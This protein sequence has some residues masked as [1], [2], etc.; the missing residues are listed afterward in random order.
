MLAKI[1]KDTCNEGPGQETL[2]LARDE[3]NVIGLR[4]DYA[5]HL[6]L[7]HAPQNGNHFDIMISES[8]RSVPF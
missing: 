4:H 6:C 1:N 5:T 8:I 2:M 3:H 7:C